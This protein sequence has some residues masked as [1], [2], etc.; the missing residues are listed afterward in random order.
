LLICALLGG[1]ASA[2]PPAPLAQQ[3]LAD[4]SF[5]PP[6]ER[7]DAG[8]VLALSDAMSRY[9]RIDIAAQLRTQGRQ[10]GL[11]DALYHRNQLK[12]EYDA[13][14]TRNAA[15]AFDARAGNC[16][17]LVIMTA[18][19]AK[20]LG[21]KVEFQSAWTEEAWLRSGD[22]YF[23]SGHVNITLGKRIA[24]VGT[25]FDLN[26]VTIDFLP[27]QPSRTLHTSPI[28]EQRVI[29]MYMNNRAAEALVQ[30]HL[31]D[32]YWWAR[33]SIAQDPSFMSAV[34]TL[35]VIYRRHGD[36]VR[37]EAVF[38]HVLAQEP[39]NTRAMANLAQLLDNVGRSAEATEL[40]A[41]LAQ[42]EP[43]PPFHFFNLGL[44]AMQNQ[45]FKTARELFAKEVDR[46]DYYHEF[47]F[48][49]GLASFKLGDYDAARKQLALAMENSG[50][51]G[52]RDIY[53]AKL[54]WLKSQQH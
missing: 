1:C 9:L 45:D 39:V 28:T 37:S 51:R 36:S 44:A 33:E 13:S 54:A 17:S 26:T 22:L 23:R 3:L 49:L 48:W 5:E 53:A 11:V 15:Q 12:L 42:L 10:R 4:S 35:G 2:P 20:E 31:G 7:I 25:G 27:E 41:R 47:H 16:L 43:Y 24:D 21:L 19:L 52:E 18:A 40:K 29:A 8:Q 46:A 34:N 38:R 50:S 14:M 30:G 32:A 6:S